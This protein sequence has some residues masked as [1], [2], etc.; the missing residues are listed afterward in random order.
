MNTSQNSYTRGR[1]QNLGYTFTNTLSYNH[2]INEH[3][4]TVLL[5]TEVRDGSG[6]GMTTIYRGIPAN[7]LKEASMNIAIDKK[8]VSSWGSE[9]QPYRLLSYFGRLNYDYM[10]KYVV[11]AI[12][13]RDGSSRF[14]S[15]N[16][17]GNFPSA[18]VRWNVQNENFWKRNDAVDAFDVRL[19]YGVNG[20]D[21]PWPFK[22]T[23]VMQNVGGICLEMTRF[24]LVMLLNLLL[25]LI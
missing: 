24:L 6:S 9:D 16:A 25:T 19:G 21:I 4:F 15:N 12:V 23:S 7:N 2:K 8:N 11:T 17:F 14:G 13:R 22:Y 20:A 3:N 5:G 18:A 1:Y 10:D